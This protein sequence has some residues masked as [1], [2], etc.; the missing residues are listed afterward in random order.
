MYQGLYLNL[1]ADDSSDVADAE[2]EDLDDDVGVLKM[3]TYAFYH[4]YHYM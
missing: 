2:V 4:Y 3:F 1:K